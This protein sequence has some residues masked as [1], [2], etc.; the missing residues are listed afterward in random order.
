[1]EYDINEV[2]AS[3]Q[4]DLV[5]DPGQEN[6]GFQKGDPIAY[7]VLEGG[8]VSEDFSIPLT[9]ELKEPARLAGKRVKARLV[10]NK[11]TMMGTSALLNLV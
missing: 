1:M 3:G 2:I 4:Y 6:L 7:R 11:T 9:I 8:L 5:P 10:P